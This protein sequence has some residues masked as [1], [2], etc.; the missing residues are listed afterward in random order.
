MDCFLTI[1][2]YFRTNNYIN[3]ITENNNNIALKEDIFSLKKLGLDNNIRITLTKTLI[4]LHSKF[5]ST[6]SQ[7]SSSFDE[8]MISKGHQVFNH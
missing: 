3:I 6:S 8:V 7:L 4:T 1:K 5:F 2:K